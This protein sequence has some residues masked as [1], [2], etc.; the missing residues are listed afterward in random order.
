MLRLQIN[1]TRPVSGHKMQGLVLAVALLALAGCKSGP[2]GNDAGPA[3][4]I[5]LS[6]ATGGALLE[7]SIGDASNLIPMLAGDSS[8]HSVASL[9]FD[10]LLTYDRNQDQLEPRLASSWDVSEDGLEITFHL[11]EDVRW[12]DGEPFTAR[13]IEYGFK[14]ITDPT[15]LTAYAEDYRQVSLFEVIDDFTFK[16]TYDKPFAPALA[17]WN[18]LV[19][20][21]RH[22]LEGRDINSATD[23]ARH[24]VGLG[25]YTLESWTAGT[26]ISL[27]AN[28]DYYRGRAYVE[29]VVYRIIPDQQT[30]FLELKTGGLDMMGL[31][32]LQYSRQTSSDA[33]KNNFARYKYLANSYTYLGY[34][35]RNDLFKDQRVRRALTH[36]INK[37][38]IVDAVLLGLGAPA[39][40]PYKP[41]TFW[42][43]DSIEDLAF[44]P[45]RSRQLL[46]EAG[47]SDS[48]DNG[49]LDREGKEFEFKILTN[50]GNDLRLKTATIIQRRFKEI[51]VKADVRVIE[52]S[53]FINDF[54]DKRAFDAVVLGWSLGL[55]PD[56]YDIWHSSKT[57]EKEF[58]FVSFAD[59]EVDDL[60]DSARRSFDRQE[61][62]KAYDR[63]QEILVEQQPYTFLYVAESLPAVHRRFHGI[64]PAP[65]G[66]AYNFERWYV[67]AALQKH[68][69]SPGG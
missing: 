48:D 60:L 5:D 24:P 3:A 50:Q 66:I 26:T 47:W 54:V 15:T 22:L 21:P 36:A 62:K 1:K 11:R 33:F 28:H 18:N 13:D 10:P 27:R 61:R 20:L 53:A 7:G 8:S 45:A 63:F 35:L 41:G 23:F 69:L 39:R 14:T 38:E 65:A 42:H 6:P 37:Q 40:V 17:S 67:P 16:V 29:R 55:D 4:D 46:A 58:N 31:T 56:Q 64:E 52:W 59:Q 44:D 43:N 30:Q 34:N 2:G 9:V 25:R 57:S 12:Q 68:S 19:V 49:V 32:P 51:G